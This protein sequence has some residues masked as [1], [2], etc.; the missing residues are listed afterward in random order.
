MN[1]I[2]AVLIL[3]FALLGVNIYVPIP[4]PSP[5]FILVALAEVAV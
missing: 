3:K 5:I 1:F 4:F 2:L